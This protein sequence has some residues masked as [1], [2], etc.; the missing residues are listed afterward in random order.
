MRVARELWTLF[1]P[2]HAVTYFTPEARDAYEAAGLRGYWRG[3][4]AGR[5]A[6]LGR[7]GAEPVV[8]AFY[9]FAPAM[10]RRALPAVWDLAGPE[11]TLAARRAG[12]V[13]ALRRVLGDADVT[14]AAE[15][16]ESAV[17]ALDLGGHVL[18][19]AHAAVTVPDEPYA[20]LW[21]AA[22]VLREHRGDGHVAAYVA[23]D[24]DGCESLVLRASLD[25]DRTWLQPNRGWT[26][27]EWDAATERLRER[28]LLGSAELLEAVEAATDAAAIRAWR[29]V[30][31]DRA[32]TVLTPL[33]AAAARVIPA[34]SPLGLPVA[35]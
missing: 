25:L 9:G 23:H 13:A 1:E 16:L 7:V 31:V 17:A 8:A 11:E 21:H 20:R 18:G 27:D 26:D 33:A 19:A 32:R 3:Y 29:A 28:R 10:V 6:P 15:I 35:R 30:D 22:G 14:E 5:A 24:V 2:L 4:F 34:T 12:A